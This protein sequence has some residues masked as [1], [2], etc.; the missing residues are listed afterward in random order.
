MTLSEIS[1][2]IE[3]LQLE[4]KKIGAMQEAMYIATFL[5]RELKEEKAEVG[6]CEITNMLNDLNEKFQIAV[7]E[8]F[9]VVRQ[10]KGRKGAI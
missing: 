2:K 3:D 10:Y 8:L 9:E 6:Y 1:Y 4:A 5:E 7:N